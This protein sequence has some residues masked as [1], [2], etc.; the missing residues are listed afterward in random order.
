MIQAILEQR[1]LVAMAIAMAAGTAGLRA[2]PVD[3][4]NVYLQLIELQH[5]TAFL[6]LV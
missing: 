2:F 1:A 6:V 4:T 3:R 5:P